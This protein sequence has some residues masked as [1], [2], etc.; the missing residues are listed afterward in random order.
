MA[1]DIFAADKHVI[2]YIQSCFWNEQYCFCEIRRQWTGE[3]W[4]QSWQLTNRMSTMINN[5]WKTY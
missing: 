4:E 5:C 2:F 1:G 3:D